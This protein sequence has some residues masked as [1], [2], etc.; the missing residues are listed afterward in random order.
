M[1]AHFSPISG[2]VGISYSRYSAHIAFT[3]SP[4][5]R[6]C[7]AAVGSLRRRSSQIAARS[8]GRLRRFCNASHSPGTGFAMPTLCSVVSRVNSY[9][10]RSNAGARRIRS[11]CWISRSGISGF[12]TSRSRIRCGRGSGMAQSGVEHTPCSRMI[13]HSRITK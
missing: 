8:P 9:W 12:G 13:G 5:D 6:N 4:L 11:S 3:G 10:L 7:S 2:E 1:G